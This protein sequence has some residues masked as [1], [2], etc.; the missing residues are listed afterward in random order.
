MA[1]CNEAPGRFVLAAAPGVRDTMAGMLGINGRQIGEVTGDDRIALRVADAATGTEGLEALSLSLVE[2][3][4]DD[5]VRAFTG[6][7]RS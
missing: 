1:L 4:I 2:I 7:D 5:A 3:G 6:G